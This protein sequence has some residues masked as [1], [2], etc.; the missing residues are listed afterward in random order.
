MSRAFGMDVAA[1]LH[2]ILVLALLVVVPLVLLRMPSAATTRK[3]IRKA[4]RFSHV[5]RPVRRLMFW[6]SLIYMFL[7]FWLEPHIGV[8]GVLFQ[9]GPLL[10]LGLFAVSIFPK[11]RYGKDEVS[12]CMEGPGR[13]SLHVRGTGFVS[14]FNRQLR[15]GQD[16]RAPIALFLQDYTSEL[17][18]AGIRTID[19][20]SPDIPE[21]MVRSEQRVVAAE[22]PRYP[23]WDVSIAEV[24]PVQHFERLVMQGMRLG[25]TVGDSYRGIQLTWSPAFGHNK[26]VDAP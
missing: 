12:L 5:N 18:N 23:G 21:R 6:G 19:V 11:A 4:A 22:A 13:G 8:L 7:V 3:R 1:Y 15:K 17:V 16:S 9:F 2:A 14:I 26:D 25:R 24:V 10:A 20:V